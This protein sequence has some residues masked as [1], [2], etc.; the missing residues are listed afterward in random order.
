MRR[1][2]CSVARLAINLKWQI[3]LLLTIV[4]PSKYN[5][6]GVNFA[7]PQLCDMFYCTIKFRHVSVIHS[8]F[9][10][11]RHYG[12]KWLLVSY[13]DILVESLEAVFGV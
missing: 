10:F 12:L 8:S 13:D 6:S 3:S 9:G 5:G 7:L 11:I 1:T 4:I 2:E